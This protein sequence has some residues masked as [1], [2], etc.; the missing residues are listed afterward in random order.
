[1]LADSL[2]HSCTKILC[3]VT[4]GR[5]RRAGGSTRSTH[6][7]R[8]VTSSSHTLDGP[9]TKVLVPGRQNGLGSASGTAPHVPILAPRIRHHQVQPG[10]L[11]LIDGRHGDVPRAHG[12]IADHVL[13]KGGLRAPAVL[14]PATCPR[15]P[16]DAP[17]RSVPAHQH[18]T[19]P[20]T[21]IEGEPRRTRGASG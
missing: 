12:A 14:V 7:Q 1:M 2:R 19:V 15:G 20:V 16:R 8:R 17:K 18:V 5:R 10:V 21:V 6:R 9:G 11:Q 3:V 4:A 13:H